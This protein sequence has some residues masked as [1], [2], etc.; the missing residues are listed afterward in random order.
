[1]IHMNEHNSSTS[2]AIL[3]DEHINCTN[4]SQINVLYGLK[5]RGVMVT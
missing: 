3:I 4:E 1:M 2:H 5:W